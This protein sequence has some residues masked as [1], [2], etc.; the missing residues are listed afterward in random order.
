M[1]QTVSEFI[2]DKMD[3]IPPTTIEYG[4]GDGTPVSPSKTKNTALGILLG[5]FLAMAV[6]VISYM[7]NDTIMTTE[8]VEKKLGMVVLASLPLEEEEGR[9]KNSK[10]KS[11]KKKSA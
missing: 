6:V 4:S 9:K 10:K 7:L 1:A 11:K 8:D 5:A 2:A 3:Q